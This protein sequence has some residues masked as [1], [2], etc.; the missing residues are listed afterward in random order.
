MRLSRAVKRKLSPRSYVGN[1]SPM[2]CVLLRR[3]D[4]EGKMRVGLDT[5]LKHL[6]MGA[7][8]DGES[9]APAEPRSNSSQLY[10]RGS[11]SGSLAAPVNLNGVDMGIVKPLAPATSKGG[12]LPVETGVGQLPDPAVVYATISSKLMV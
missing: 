8:P 6:K 1:I 11:L 7:V 10:V 12:L 5:G 9:G 4:S 2:V 3:S